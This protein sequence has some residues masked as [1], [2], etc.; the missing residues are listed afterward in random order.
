MLSRRI[1]RVKV[2][3]ALFT[4]HTTPELTTSD[5]LRFYDQAVN[6]SYDLLSYHL[7]LLVK[8]TSHAQEDNDRR[9]TKLLPTD[10]DKKFTPK[11]F[12]NK[13]TQSIAKDKEITGNWEKIDAASF[14][15][16]DF[17]KKLYKTFS[18]SE[19]YLGY[20]QNESSDEADKEILLTFYKD[21]VKQEFFNETVEDYYY[22]WLDD[23]SII[24]GTMKKILKALPELSLYDRY[25][26]SQETIVDFG[27]NLL[28]YILENDKEI[29][30]IVEPL[31]ENWDIDRVATIDMI[32]LKMAIAEM[33][34]FPS[35]PTKVTINEYV[36]LTKI[37]STDK[38]KEFINGILDKVLQT[39]SEDKKIIKSGRGLHP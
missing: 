4:W 7:Y 13:M 33:I 6:A 9:K 27:R 32:F 21:L 25:G 39:L 30:Q 26:P 11:L 24:V 31:I 10:L 17:T 16:E 35:I 8:S 19:S 12:T 29:I 22:N 14:T 18:L 36:D 20:V 34:I 28:S 3:Q 37:Y 2:M 5:I 15:P 38:S 23:E 1:I